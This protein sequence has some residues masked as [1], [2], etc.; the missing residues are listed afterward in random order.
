MCER[1]VLQLKEDIR[2]CAVP[3]HCIFVVI[4]EAGEN[5]GPGQRTSTVGTRVASRGHRGFLDL[6]SGPSPSLVMN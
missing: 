2:I 4:P 3:A 6:L 1:S 5:L